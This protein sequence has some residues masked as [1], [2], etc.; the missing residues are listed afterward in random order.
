MADSS[1]VLVIIPAFNE[2]KN[3]RI[4]IE[5]TRAAQMHARI[6]VVDDGSSDRTAEVAR[7]A[8]ATVVSLPF[9]LGYGVAVQTGFRFAVRGRF[10]RI[11]L[12]DGDG[13]HDPRF[14][15]PLL[16]GLEDSDVVRGSR[17]LGA[18]RYRIPATR[19]MGMALFGAIAGFLTGDRVTDVTSGFQAFD[20]RAVRFLAENYPSDYPDADTVILIKR[21]GLSSR[22]IPVEMRERLSGTP[23]V[24]W[25]GS[26]YYVFKMCLSILVTLLREK[27]VLDP[28]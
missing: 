18:A 24:S 26:F 2:E 17:F 14:V 9:N 7:S 5:E 19:R 20:E 8:G 15:G 22:E 3:L 13:Q 25:P 16:E 12:L 1:D 23:M 28:D 27:P 11:V 21:A 6:L 4:V 10:R